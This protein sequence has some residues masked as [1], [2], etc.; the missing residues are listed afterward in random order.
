M[1]ASVSRRR[2]DWDVVLPGSHARRTTRE[3]PPSRFLELTADVVATPSPATIDRL[4]RH[5]I[6]YTR[7]VLEL[8]RTSLYLL[9]A[10]NNVMVGTFGTGA[11][12]ETVDERGLMYEV[13][14]TDRE[15]FARAE[16]GLPWIVYDNCP[17]VVQLGG[18]TRAI[19]RGWVACTAVR[20]AHHPIGVFYNDSALSHA[21]FD[22]AK[23]SSLAVLC[24]LLGRAL[25]PCRSFLLP[26]VAGGLSP[27]HAVVQQVTEALSRDPRLSCE[28]LARDLRLTPRHLSRTFKHATQMSLVEYRNEL[29]L[30]RF[31]DSVDADADRLLEAAREA[32]FG[33]YA[34][35][36]RVFHARYRQ[37][38][39]EYVLQRRRQ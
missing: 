15:V 38:P 28:A 32:G 29:R 39:R 21:P 8:E 30:A 35:F 9:D 26:T 7:V 6:E 27:Q 10:K 12:R 19:G 4:L 20:G 24:S 33:S 17:H 13:G 36:H 31:L 11:S 2:V 22:E 5:A 34:Q 37:S 18:K 1:P 25:E 23:Q 14:P 3:T 16:V